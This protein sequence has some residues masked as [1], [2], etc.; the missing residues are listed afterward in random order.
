VLDKLFKLTV[1]DPA[2]KTFANLYFRAFQPKT[3]RNAWYDF[4]TDSTIF[5]PD[6]LYR[7]GDK[8]FAVQ[9]DLKMLVYA[10]IES[11]DAVK[12]VQAM[13]RNH[14]N[15]RMLFGD[16]K[17][18]KA[19]DP[20]TQETIYEVVYVEMVDEYE[21]NNISISQTVELPDYINSRVLV[22]YDAIKVDSDIPF[23]S[24]RDHQRVFPNSVK[25]MRQ[26]I[27]T[28]GDRDRDLLP[29]WMRSIQD[30]A[31]F[32]TGYISVL[33]LCYTKPN[34]SSEIVARVKASGF[35]FKEIDFVADRYIIDILDG[36]IEDKYLAFP[37]R[38]EKLP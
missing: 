9:T 21:K 29:L 5:K 14:Y 12:Y 15:K 4:I 27:K 22:S 6:L 17:S 1:E 11:T 19:K 30:Q 32:E 20:I 38:G 3:K 25:N 13:S 33:P 2:N 34:K 8:N 24:D 37:Q 35:D 31:T 36:Q 23:V 10:G 26:R 16:V 18:A 28:V 7:Y